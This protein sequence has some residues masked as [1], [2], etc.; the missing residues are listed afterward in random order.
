MTTGR[1]DAVSEKYYLEFVII[2]TMTRVKKMIPGGMG[3]GTD[4]SGKK[5]FFWNAL[6]DD[7]IEDFQVVNNKSHFI[8]AIATKIKRVPC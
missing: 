6:P 3:L 2:Y 5:V 8:E 4:E 1:R 7:L